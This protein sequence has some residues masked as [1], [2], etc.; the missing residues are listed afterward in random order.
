MGKKSSTNKKLSKISVLLIVIFSVVTIIT[1]VSEIYIS[2]YDIVKSIYKNSSTSFSELTS[3][4]KAEDFE[5]YYNTMLSGFP[6][7]E[8]YNNVL[9]FDFEEKKEYYKELAVSAGSDFEFYCVMSAVA[10]EF[11]SFH[12]DIVYPNYESYKSLG[13]YNMTHTL[14]NNKVYPASIYWNELLKNEYDNIHDVTFYSYTYLNGEYVL[15]DE[16]GGYP[17]GTRLTEI[18]GIDINTYVYEHLFSSCSKKYDSLNNNV[19]I[20]NFYVNDKLGDPI[21]MTLILPNGETVC[22]KAY[23]DIYSDMDVVLYNAY[24]DNG[25]GFQSV[26][27][28]PVYSFND[29]DNSIGYI[30]LGSMNYIFK[31]EIAENI[32]QISKNQSVIIDLRDN[33]GGSAVIG[34]KYIYPYI[35]SDSI[36]VNS[37][38]YMLDSS[39]NQCVKK[40]DISR[41]IFELRLAPT[42]EKPERNNIGWLTSYRSFD[43]NG[44]SAY[45]PNV[46]ILINN[47]T[48]SAAD[49]FV[50]ALKNSSAVTVIGENTA[51]EG[52]ADSF[53]CNYLPNSGLVFIYMYGQAYN[54]DGTDNSL[55]GT[56]PDIYS[57]IDYDGY[58]KCGELFNSSIDPYTYENRLEWD[59]VLT[60]TLEIIKEKENSK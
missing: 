22:E 54:S 46:Y 29:D 14:C 5:Y 26:L 45:Q 48:G 35:F 7:F 53:I 34:E 49:G 12:T 47:G 21:E 52:L 42:D 16:F 38:W 1:I 28:Q 44:E 37:K 59:N 39:N 27:G 18:D 15:I 41:N 40:E 9:E 31:D 10:N 30:K 25:S 36:N 55:Y 2:R 17:S 60:E 43:Y 56:A 6:M 3:E 33:Y 19:Y 4:Q 23:Q 32:K 11:P 57:F 20:N 51:G 13:C 58:K 50:S 8:T 24:S